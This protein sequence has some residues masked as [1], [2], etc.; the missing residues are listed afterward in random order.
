MTM[1]EYLKYYT[2]LG[3]SVFPVKP[4]KTPYT[5]HG[6]KDATNDYE[7]A[8]KLFA[9]YPD[10]LIG[11]ATGAISGI[12]VLDVDVKRQV[13]GQPKPGIISL[14]VLT[15]DHGELPETMRQ[16]TPSEGRHYFFKRKKDN[17]MK[18]TVNFFEG[19]DIRSDNAYVVLASPNKAH[20]KNSKTNEEIDGFYKWENIDSVKELAFAPDWLIQLTHSKIQSTGIE[21]S[22]LQE[23]IN[24]NYGKDV[25]VKDYGNY[26]LT[27]CYHEGHAD[28]HPSM[29]ISKITGRVSCLSCKYT[30]TLENDFDIKIPQT[31]YIEN[32]FIYNR[33]DIIKAINEVPVPYDYVLPALERGKIALV[34]ASSGVGKSFF[35][36]QTAISVATGVPLCGGIWET[37]TSTFPIRRVTIFFAED[38][39][40]D[41]ERRIHSISE[42]YKSN[43]INLKDGLVA[44]NLNIVSL[45]GYVPELMDKE[46]NISKS[47]FYDAII[48]YCEGSE[49]I[50][51][52]PYSRFKGISDENSNAFANRFVQYLEDIAK[53]DNSSILITQHTSKFSSF[54]GIGDQKE[55]GRGASALTDAVRLQINLSTMT[56]KEAQTFLINGSLERIED[57]RKFL[58]VTMSKVNYA[59]QKPP[60]WLHR[61]SGGVLMKTELTQNGVVLSG[62][63]KTK[64]RRSV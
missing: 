40:K 42:V 35:V 51:L 46:G 4:D 64:N 19:L 12:E 29:L 10:A 24:K 28:E 62:S 7:K 25:T 5:P 18:T 15:M 50:I 38:S 47:G 1:N 48:K 2:D 54:N 45:V 8:V 36:L 41:I 26:F 32:I 11:V 56:E 58:K 59:E 17:P 21:A 34:V 61:E 16:I 13:D 30:S 53:R 14:E 39:K 23:Q 9:Q 60:V 63:K 3:W 27:N 22:I 57:R 33:I 37:S 6:F 52:D 55:A 31:Q 49:L 20:Y 43:D 44:E